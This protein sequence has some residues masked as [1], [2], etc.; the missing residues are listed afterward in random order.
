VQIAYTPEGWASLVK[1]P[2]NR[3]EKVRPAIEKVG[4]KLREGFFAFGDYDIVAIAE[5]PNNASAAAISIAFAAGGATK[6]VKTTPLLTVEETMD[7]LFKAGESGYQ[8]ATKQTVE[9]KA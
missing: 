6:S 2:Q 4:G 7:A 1:N 9:V 8:P 3:F 5:F